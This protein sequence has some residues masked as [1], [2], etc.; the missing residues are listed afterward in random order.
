MLLTFNTIILEH[1]GIGSWSFDCRQYGPL[2]T[3]KQHYNQLFHF[4]QALP[5]FV[6]FFSYS[7]VSSFSGMNHN[8]TAF[9]GCH[10]GKV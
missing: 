8:S 7:A 10:R 1:T 6:I 9:V 5:N 3:R 2:S 4:A